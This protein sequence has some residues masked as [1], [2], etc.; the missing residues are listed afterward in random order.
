MIQVRC[1]ECGYVQ[2]L[3]EER[4]VALKED[5]L[6]CPHCS[7]KVPKHWDPTTGETVP[8]ETRHKMLAFSRRIL[9]GRN[10]AAEVVYAL[11]ALVRH[12]GPLEDSDKALGVGYATLGE[13]SK[14][15]EFLVRAGEQAPED[16]QVR[17]GLLQVYVALGKF[18]EAAEIGKA[19]IDECG[20]HSNPEDVVRLALAMNGLSR[21]E[22]ARALLD[23]FPDLDARN[24]VVKHA[25]K[26]INRTS[27]RGLRSLFGD[28]G[29]I[30]RLFSGVGKGGLLRLGHRSGASRATAGHPEDPQVAAGSVDSP[31]G[32]QQVRQTQSDVLPEV[33]V[34]LEYWIYTQHTDIP[35]WE[36]IRR[37]LAGQ[38][39]EREER[40][41]TFAFLEC[42][43]ERDELAIEYILKH[44]A[45]DLFDYPE[46]MI[47]HNA[48]EFGEEDRRNLL[49][50]AMIV[51]IRL[52]L[53]EPQGLDCLVFMLK[54]VE[55][56]RSCTSGIVQD[57]VSHALWGGDPWK[58][59]VEHGAEM[60]IE[61]HIQLEILE[62][63]SGV[64]I[65]THGMQ[66]FGLP[67]LEAEGIPAEWAHAGRKLVIKAS[68]ALA[69]MRESGVDLRSPIELPGTQVD[70]AVG[71]RPQDEEGHF[72][73]GSARLFPYPRHEAATD[74]DSVRRALELLATPPQAHI[75]AAEDGKHAP[76][77]SAPESPEEARTNELREKLISAHRQARSEL[78]AFK[79]SFQESRS[80]PDCVHAVKVGFAVRSGIYE[81]MWVSL[82]EWRGG[83]MMGHLENT[84]QLRKDLHKGNMVHIQEGEIFDWVITKGGDVHQ[85]AFTEGIIS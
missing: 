11:E 60:T 77:D 10:L 47:P 19:L 39:P 37:M 53:A 42:L 1:P 26:E 64:W 66:K 38:L 56:V 57:A 7:A 6:T 68:E 75:Q 48:K 25:V 70:V 65:H 49:D 31:H 18:H 13:N 52:S 79:R 72:P 15:E 40:E 44:D 24:P 5:F 12:Y 33:P 9:N 71:F 36:D 35:K 51:R 21:S 28:K 34:V 85:G 59:A 82:G 46:E 30:K 63:G 3:S 81:W 83:S 69:A 32:D 78:P 8:E 16:R 45:R 2:T 58:A 62:E 20:S 41:Q 27:S 73:V 74:P 29:T 43:V 61:S 80:V 17:Q 14:A 4:F 54:F 76:V 22:D 50:A 67:D 23:R 84:P 55:A